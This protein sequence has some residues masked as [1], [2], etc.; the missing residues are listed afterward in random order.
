MGGLCS[1]IIMCISLLLLF[2]ESLQHTASFAG[3]TSDSTVTFCECCND[4]TLVREVLL[5]FLH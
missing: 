4:V 1:V 3:S 5:V 2:N